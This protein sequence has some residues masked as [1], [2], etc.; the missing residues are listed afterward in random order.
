VSKEK[1]KEERKSKK[2]F[3]KEK[4]LFLSLTSELKK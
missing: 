4:K 2:S 3:Q 1:K